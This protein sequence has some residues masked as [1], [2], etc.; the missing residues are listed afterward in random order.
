[1][2]FIHIE[3]KI[4]IIILSLSKAKILNIYGQ[5]FIILMIFLSLKLNMEF[6]K[7]S[8]LSPSLCSVID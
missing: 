4:Q 7:L 6:N 8:L 5:D 1:M 3:I 2:V